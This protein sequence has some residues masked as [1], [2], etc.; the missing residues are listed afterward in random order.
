[1]RAA[2]AVFMLIRRMTDTSFYITFIMHKLPCCRL[3]LIIIS[4]PPSVKGFFAFRVFLCY[5]NPKTAAAAAGRTLCAY[6]LPR[7]VLGTLQHAKPQHV[8]FCWGRFAA[9]CYN[10]PKTAAA[11][12][13]HTLCAYAAARLCARVDSARAGESM[14]GL[15]AFLMRVVVE[16]G[17]S[18]L[19]HKTG[20]L[21]IRLVETL[22]KTLADLQNAGHQIV[23]VSSGAI[24][25]GVGKLQLGARPS[26]MATKQAAAAVG[27]CELMY[28]YDKLF[29]EYNH[30]VAQ[31]LLTA[32]DIE[33]KMRRHNVET[34]R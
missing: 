10:N 7:V 9:S 28:T 22:C 12:A 13:G 25:M 16:V 31:V 3:Q 23:L 20:C 29:T 6:A 19:A 8:R 11:A 21:N 14:N 17:T 18:T 27:Q 32:A 2:P 15:G 34:T 4:I 26:D 33:D 5:N 24:G 1:M 30:T